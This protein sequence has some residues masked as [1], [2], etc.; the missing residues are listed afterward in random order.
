MSIACLLGDSKLGLESP[1]RGV[2][3]HAVSLATGNRPTDAMRGTGEDGAAYITGFFGLTVL[4]VIV[5]V[6][7]FGI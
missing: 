3:L 5:T 1:Q 7:I 6:W 2:R 4:G